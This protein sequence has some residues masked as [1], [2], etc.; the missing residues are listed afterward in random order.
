ME[1]LPAALADLSAILEIYNQGI[2]DRIATLE[3][4]PKNMQYMTEWFTNR[5]GR[6]AVIVAKEQDEVIGWCSINPYNQRCAY[7]GVGDPSIYVRRDWRGKGVGRKLML[8][9]IEIAKESGFRKLVLATLANNPRAHSLYRGIG[10]RDVG[11]FLNQGILDGKFMDVL[12]MEML[13]D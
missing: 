8:S 9:I 12:I 4:N 13:F 7:A 11:V 5:A 6:Y 3:E 10:F 1:I 2:A